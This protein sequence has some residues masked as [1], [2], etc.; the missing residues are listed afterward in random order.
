MTHLDT[1]TEACHNQTGLTG[2]DLQKFVCDFLAHTAKKQNKA[3]HVKAAM[4][5]KARV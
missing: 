2:K 4:E 5:V 1:V 3:H